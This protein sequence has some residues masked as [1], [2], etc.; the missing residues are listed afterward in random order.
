MRTVR[1]LDLKEDIRQRC[2]LPVFSTGTYITTASVERMINVSLHGLYSLMIQAWGEGYFTDRDTIV[3]SAGART[4][5]LPANFLKLV[6]VMWLRGTDDIVPVPEASVDE[7]DYGEF[8]ARAWDAPKYRLHFNALYWLP[9]PNALYTLA[10]DYVY[11]PD[12]LT[13]DYDTTDV[14]PGWDEWVVLDCCRKIYERQEKDP[15][16]F[17]LERNRVEQNILA[18]SPHRAQSE[19]SVVRD[20][21]EHLLGQRALRD[22]LWRNGG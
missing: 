18:V 5:S 3:T 11:Q 17:M 14:G 10:I 7:R 6:R 20:A 2:E 12:D 21:E 19:N 8:A 16:L 13:D 4:T 9:T 22:Y 1:L 15:Q